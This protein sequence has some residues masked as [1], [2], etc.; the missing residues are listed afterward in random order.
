MTLSQAA[1]VTRKGMVF[2]G[3]FLAVVL[4]SLIGYRLW[5]QYELAHS[6]PVEEK[7]EMRFGT[8]PKIKF[9][10]QT[11]SSS[12][13]TYSLDTTTGELPEVPKLLKIYFIPL[14]G[15]SLMDADKAKKLAENLKFPDGPQILASTEY[16]F[17]DNNGSNLLINIATG[18]FHF[19]RTLIPNQDDPPRGSFPDKEKLISDFKDFLSSKNILYQE[20]SSGT[21][22]V[23]Y[24]GSGEGEIAQ[25]SLWPSD[26]DKTKI[27]TPQFTQGLIRASITKHSWEINKYI[28]INFT[29]WPVD[30]TTSS[31]YPLKTPNQ[32]FEELKAGSG[33]VAVEPPQPQVSI[34]SVYLAYYQSES[35]SPYL[36]PVYVFDGPQFITLVPAVGTPIPTTPN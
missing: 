34:S 6:K 32:A 27:I 14:T 5:K 20:L 11:V 12:N 31:T 24:S 18:N 28:N 35:Y 23:T 9:P 30:K 10:P 25:I 36:Q 29:F 1:V 2:L 7:P 16:K 21:G 19:Q 13:F 26:I 17:T 3:I 4:I 33:F 8:L 22:N 15:V